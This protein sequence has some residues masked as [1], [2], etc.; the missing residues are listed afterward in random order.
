M[1]QR[2]ST[3][4]VLLLL[5]GFAVTGCQ[6]QKYETSFSDLFDTYTTITGYS[7]SEDEF[8]VYAAAIYDTMWY[9]HQLFDIYHEY[10]GIVNLKTIN[11]NAGGSPIVVS[12]DLFDFLLWA[13]EAYSTTGGSVNIALG[14]VLRL[15]EDCRTKSESGSGSA[16]IPDATSLSEALL[17]THID[18]LILDPSTL[19]VY[20]SDPEASLDVGALA[21]GYAV[22]MAA[23][24][25]LDA[26]FT[27]GLINAGGNVRCIGMPQDGRR[28]AFSIGIQ[29]PNE[30]A[31]TSLFDTV[32]VTDLSIVTSGDYQRYFIV[33]GTRYHHILDPATAMPA[34][35]FRSVTVIHADSKIA[36]MLSTAL[37][38]LPY[39]KGLALAT[40]YE[41]E[42]LW[43]FGDLTWEATDGYKAMSQTLTP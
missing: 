8:S 13:K 24:K 20:L 17:H 22:E 27:S 16:S 5:L 40:S 38:I 37:F 42:V 11:D 18:G 10:E 26:G 39:E 28:N 35:R 19:T 14:P 32:Q 29:N 43:I 3:V 21:K 33:D 34:N 15:W 31:E 30:T 2:I 4:A 1:N 41:A 7:K 36:D 9:Y 23:K 6:A 25:A 12:Q